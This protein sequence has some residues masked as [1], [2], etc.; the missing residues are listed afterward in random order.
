MIEQVYE[1]PPN[2]KDIEAVFGKDEKNTLLYCYGDKLYNPHKLVLEYHVLV[3]EEVHVKQQEKVCRDEWWKRYLSD[4]QFRLDQELGAYIA[5]YKWVK[6]RVPSKVSQLF[7]EDI[8][9]VLAG[10]TYGHLLT[11]AQAST[12]I[13]KSLQTV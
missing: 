13:R 5:Q 9:Q 3:H 8:S 6:E 2:I 7:L 10:E 11:P 4:V 1:Y 12:K